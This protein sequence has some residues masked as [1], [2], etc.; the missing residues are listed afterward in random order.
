MADSNAPA[1][2]TDDLGPNGRSSVGVTVDAFLDG[3]VVPDDADPE[4]AAAIVAAVSAH[5]TD[6]EL[7]AAESR[8][9]T[10]E[11]WNGRRWAF[12]GR[13]EAVSGRSVR[14]TE[15]TPTDPWTAV[16]RADRL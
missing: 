11:T 5:L 9:E 10:A 1:E 14:V 8:E 4:E 2:S 3:L 15:D 13:V 6:L 12:T 16:G 7:A